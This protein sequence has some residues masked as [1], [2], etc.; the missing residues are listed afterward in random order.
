MKGCF[1]D[2]THAQSPMSLRILVVDDDR[3]IRSVLEANLKAVGY[4]VVCAENG[5]Q[6][7]ELFRKEYF[8]IVMTDWIMPEISGLDLC[9][10]IRAD[11]SNEGYT[12]IIVMTSLDSKN[13]IIAGL[14]AGADEY[15]IKPVHQAELQSRLRTARRI[16]ELEKARRDHVLQIAS[17][18]LIDQVSNVFNRRYMEEHIPHEIKRAY[19]YERSLSLIMISIRDFDTII[20]THGYYTGDI[21][22]KSCADCLVEAVRK[23]IDWLARYS[24]S[25][26]IAVLPET[27]SAGA[28]ILATRVKIRISAMTIRSN[29]VDIKLQTCIGVTG[30]TANQEKQGFSADMML[31]RASECLAKA[32]EEE[33]NAIKGVQIV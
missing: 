32:R 17:M 28:M 31:Q 22:L 3:L 20:A 30:F 23:D 9:R 25:E 16:L 11:S 19:R 26:F 21:V 18:S 1:M 29:N 4:T 7:L 12:Y 15:L 6:A 8:P 2:T 27:D 5:R 24:E 33:G 10:A 14:D 13:D